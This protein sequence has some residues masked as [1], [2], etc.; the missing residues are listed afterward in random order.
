MDNAEAVIEQLYK[1]P[2]QLITADRKLTY[3]ASK[4]KGKYP[5]AYADCFAAALSLN[6]AGTFDFE[7]VLA[8]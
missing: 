3:A 5:I 6:G 7:T 8:D 2:I 1:Y 4:L